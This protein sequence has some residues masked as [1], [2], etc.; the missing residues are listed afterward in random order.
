VQGVD[1]AT[2]VTWDAHKMLFVPSLAT[3]LLFREREKSF[4][5]FRQDAPYLWDPESSAPSAYDS[6]LRTLECT[7]RS[8]AMGIWGVWALYGEG[9]FEDLVD[10]TFDLARE[11]HR[12]IGA[13]SDF[14]TLHE[15]EANILCF[16]YRPDA[17]RNLTS[18]ELSQRQ[19]A[20]RQRVVESGEFY[21]TRTKL[22]GE[23]VLRVTLM[24]PFSELSHL[25]ALLDCL[26]KHANLSDMR[27]IAD[28]M[29]RSMVES[30]VVMESKKPPV[31]LVT[32][33]KNRTEEHIDM[34]SMTDKMRVALLKSGRFRF[35]EKEARG[36]IAEEVDY[37]GQ[38]GYVDPATAKQKGKQIGADYFLTGEITDRVQQVGSKKYVYYKA[39]FNLMNIK[40]GLQDWADEKEIRKY[41]QKRS[42]GF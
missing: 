15:P 31:V 22:D 14:E 3:F 37:Q 11:L 6:G 19:G 25:E 9:L 27:M 2:S 5:A 21:L 16:R 29:I 34:K 38:S 33:V 12:L 39:T 32:M 26:R 24:N 28:A 8:V 40:T 4:A 35:T 23:T 18:A 30:P 1:R 7:K 20:L 36:E 41:Y 42:V 17:W 10:E 13:S